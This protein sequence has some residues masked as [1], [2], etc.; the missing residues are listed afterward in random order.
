MKRQRQLLNSIF[1]V[2][3][4]QF[5]YYD[6]DHLRLICSSGVAEKVLGYSTEEFAALSGEY[7]K[8]LIHP[9]DWHLTNETAQKVLRS[10]PGEIV[11]MTARYRKASGEYIWVYTR[12]KVSKRTKTGH[13]KELIV[14]A[15]DVTEFVDLQLQLKEKVE[16]LE[17]IS[18]KN[19]HELRA[20]V[21][22]ILGLVGL[23]SKKLEG[24]HN[25]QILLYLKQSIEKLDSVIREV[26]SIAHS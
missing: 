6:V 15:E 13:P 2:A 7:F 8:Q 4:V 11:E 17:K 19:S 18:W 9:D 22:N 21:A 25:H 16:Q 10:G 1:E 20:P 5:H 12:R 24:Q 3:H 14:M 26:N 23:L